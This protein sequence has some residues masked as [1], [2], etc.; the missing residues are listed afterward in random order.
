MPFSIHGHIPLNEM[1][2]KSQTHG[3]RVLLSRNA[4]YTFATRSNKRNENQ[5]NNNVYQVTLIIKTLTKQIEKTYRK[6]Y[7]PT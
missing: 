2:T 5:I 3:E 7:E 1:H 6:S 4:N